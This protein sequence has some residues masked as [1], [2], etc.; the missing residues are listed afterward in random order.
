MTVKLNVDYE[1]IPLSNIIC[2]LLNIARLLGEQQKFRILR[3]KN[4][5]FSFGNQQHFPQ[6]VFKYLP[7]TRNMITDPATEFAFI[8]QVWT[9][10]WD[11]ICQIRS[12]TRCVTVAYN[13]T[14]VLFT[15]I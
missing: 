10:V 7:G 13:V 6:E 5:G 9:R 8:C 15:F 2:A 1:T 11:W 4:R 12:Q 3:E 14:H